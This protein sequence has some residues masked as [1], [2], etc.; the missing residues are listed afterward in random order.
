MF[1]PV[2]PHAHLLARRLKSW[3]AAQGDPLP[4]ARCQHLIA[5]L[6]GHAN[7]AALQV[8]APTVV[9]PGSFSPEIA[10]LKQFGYTAEAG[11]SLLAHLCA[12]PEYPQGN[13]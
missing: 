10:R 8:S 12:M 5:V 11:A 7:W 3:H 9:Q 6:Q 2:A 13:D 1:R 4:L